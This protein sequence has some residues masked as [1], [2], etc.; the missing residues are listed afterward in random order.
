MNEK[1]FIRVFSAIPILWQII[2][3]LLPLLLVLSIALSQKKLAVPPFQP[4]ISFDQGLKFH[5]YLGNFI[6]VITDS[7]YLFSFIHSIKIALISASLCFLIASPIAYFLA[8]SAK[9]MKSILLILIVLPFATS[10]LIRVFAWLNIFDLGGVLNAVLLYLHFIDEPVYFINSSFSVVICMAYC[11]LP[12]MMLPVYVALERIDKSILEAASDLGASPLI[13]L[14]KIIFPMALNGIYSGFALVFIP[15]VGE[16][17]IPEL[18][19][20]NSSSFIGKIVWQEFFLNRDWPL[21]AAIS[22]II[23]IILIVPVILIQKKIEE[24]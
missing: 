7:Y 20:N 2:F 5:I 24:K 8:F 13:I 21:A 4:I 9:K 6:D 19:S 10:S 23:T 15:M 3:V 14:L 22:C 11:Y 18:I 12:F 1:R 16:F 17:V